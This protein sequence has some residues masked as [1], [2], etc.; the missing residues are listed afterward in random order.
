MRRNR[1][2]G[3]GGAGKQTQTNTHKH[4]TGH[5]VVIVMALVAFI[6]GPAA[7][8][9]FGELLAELSEER[10]EGTRVGA[11][12]TFLLPEGGL[13]IQL[14]S[15]VAQ[16]ALDAHGRLGVEISFPLAAADEEVR[17]WRAALGEVPPALPSVHFA[18]PGPPVFASTSLGLADAALDGDVEPQV[19][20]QVAPLQA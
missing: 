6:Q 8:L 1:R 3:G 20:A 11:L 2:A 5:R 17:R 18:V 14:P 16:C 7:V 10:R 19:L 13:Q 15:A 9:V 12:F 4:A